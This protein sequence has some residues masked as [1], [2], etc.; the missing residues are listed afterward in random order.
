MNLKEFKQV[1]EPHH[2]NTTNGWG[3][4]GWVG[5]TYILKYDGE[6][7]EANVGKWYYR[8]LK[9]DVFE[10][11]FIKDTKVTKKEFEKYISNIFVGKFDN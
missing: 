9:P 5:T 11:F 4:Q 10:T 1:A 7:L 2:S 6:Y 8:H 3:F